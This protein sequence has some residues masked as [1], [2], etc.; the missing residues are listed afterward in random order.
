MTLKEYLDFYHN[1]FL[2]IYADTVALL[3]DKPRQLVIEQE[4]SL[5]HLTQ[6]LKDNKDIDNLK[7]AKGHLERAAL[8]AYKISWVHIKR[9]I[10]KFTNLD[11]NQL[12]LA[13]NISEDEVNKMINEFDVLIREARTLEM[14]NI[15]QKDEQAIEKYAQAVKIGYQLLEYADIKKYNL[16]NKF[17]IINVIKNQYICFGMG[18]LSSLAATYIYIMF[19]S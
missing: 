6:Y 13:F 14:N 2:P 10:E 3:A 16:W 18:I 5:S 17:R 19:T 8:D 12:A 7:K 15:G 9:K 4:N 11:T 1:T